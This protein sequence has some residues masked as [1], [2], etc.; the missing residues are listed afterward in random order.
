[1][2]DDAQRDPAPLLLHVGYHKTGTTWLQ[3]FLFNDAQAGFVQ[4]WDR[5]DIIERLVLENAF[6]FDAA[7]ARDHFQTA[8]DR[9]HA[10][11]RIP[12]CSAERLS[13][14]PHSGG[15]DA[16]QIAHRL[17]EAFPEARVLIVMREQRSMILSAYRQ[18]VR[19]GGAQSLRRYLNPPRMGRPRIPQFR[20]DYL[21]YDLLIG[22]YRD[23]F[24][25]QNV[26]ALPFETLKQD[27]DAFA[28]RIARFAGAREPAPSPKERKNVGMSAATLAIK[29]RA[30]RVL[31]RD[32]ANPSAWFDHPKLNSGV[33][34]ASDTLDRLVPGALKRTTDSRLKRIVD[35][36]TGDRYAKSNARLGAM[37]GM[38]LGALGYTVS[39]TD[40]PRSI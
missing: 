24:G 5:G 6:R 15:H 33:E 2:A 29:R 1:M 34:R 14:N 30:N 17:R 23:L 8:V 11:D 28:Q 7:Q 12:V 27:A 19:V 37:L 16:A 9:A 40:A 31:V 35:E 18:Y 4:P 39:A 10:D 13:G 26:L 32:T 3:A 38:D 20:W 22:R 21:E 25:A 36:A